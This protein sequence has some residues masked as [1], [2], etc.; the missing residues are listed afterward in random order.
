[1]TATYDE[2]DRRI[3]ALVEREGR[4]APVTVTRGMARAASDRVRLADA[5]A[6]K[7][8]IVDP[9]MWT[10]PGRRFERSSSPT[11][12]HGHEWSEANTRFTPRRDCAGTRRV[13]RACARES[14]RRRREAMPERAECPSCGGRKQPGQGRKVCDGCRTE[15]DVMRHEQRA[16]GVAAWWRRAPL[17]VPEA[18]TVEAS[19]NHCGGLAC[20]GSASGLGG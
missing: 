12:P 2:M 20:A 6:P 18:W 4:R 19:S 7:T 8:R 1:M 15:R 17:T 3:A 13:C 16:A 9:P 14:N 10:N 5:A 11:C